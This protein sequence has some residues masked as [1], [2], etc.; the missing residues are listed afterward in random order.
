MVASIKEQSVNKQEQ[1]AKIIE[2]ERQ[3]GDRMHPPS[4][5]HWM[6]LGL[7][8]VQLKSLFFIVKNSNANSKKLS[9]TLGVTPANVT[10]VIDRLIERGMVQRVESTKDRRITLLQATSK[11]KKLIASL[12]EHVVEHMA[13]LLSYLSEDELGHLHLGLAA[14]IKAWDD[15]HKNKMPDMH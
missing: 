9:D 8:T 1:I 6:S 2:L 15:L 7:T 12:D 5:R 14:F 4:Y 10:G 11:G 3:F 13:K